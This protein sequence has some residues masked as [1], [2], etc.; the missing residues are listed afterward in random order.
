MAKSAV[1]QLIDL[2]NAANPTLPFPATLDDVEVY[3]HPLVDDAGTGRNTMTYLVAKE[4]SKYF[5][6]SMTV[7]YNR[8]QT[9]FNGDVVNE[10]IALWESDDYVL[11]DMNRRLKASWPEDAFLM[12]ELDIVRGENE[13]GEY[14]VSVGWARSI[15]FQPPM[16][17]TQMYDFII[18]PPKTDLSTLNGELDGF[19]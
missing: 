17:D 2:Y 9:N 7:R 16:T 11:D 5:V 12:S 1:E 18:R 3:D 19:R 10:P 4:E 14:T 8:L 13:D 15:R 6:G